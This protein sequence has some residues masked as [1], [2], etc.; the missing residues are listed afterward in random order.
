MGLPEYILK[1]P[2]DYSQPSY[3]LPRPR[4]EPLREAPRLLSGEI[5]GFEWR[6]RADGGERGI[7][8]E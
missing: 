1:I 5:Q 3:P 7:S 2:R 6:F 4:R 8:E